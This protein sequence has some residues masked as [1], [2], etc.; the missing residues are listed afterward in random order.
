MSKEEEKTNQEI[1]QDVIQL[2][3]AE[4]TEEQIREL[5]KKAWEEGGKEAQFILTMSEWNRPGP[6]FSDYSR[7][8]IL[9]GEVE[10]ILVDHVY[11][12]PTTDEYTYFIIPKSRAVVILCE[13]GDNYQGKMQRHA[14]LY[15]FSYPKGWRTISL[16]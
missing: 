16:Y 4:L 14:K 5:V 7:I 10:Q 12:Y 3:Q 11:N 8:D 6:S 2:S 1:N 15:I 9:Y 13:Y